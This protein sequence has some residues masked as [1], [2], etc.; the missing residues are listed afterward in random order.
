VVSVVSKGQPFT[1]L[2]GAALEPFLATLEQGDDGAEIDAEPAAPAA[3]AT[4]AEAPAD[5]PA[6]APAADADGD[7]PMET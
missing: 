5:A 2:E 1:I 3:P 4:A 6:D 7:A